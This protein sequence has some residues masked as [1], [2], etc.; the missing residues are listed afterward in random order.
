MASSSSSTQLILSLFLVVSLFQVSLASSRLFQV[1]L[2]TRRLSELVQDQS[3]LLKYHNGPLLN[4]KIAINLIWYG[5]FKPAQKAIVSDFITSLSSSSPAQSNKPSVAT[6]WKTTEKYYHLTSKKSSLSI[7]LGKQISNEKY[8][9]GKSLT[10][11][12][13]V[14]LASLGDQ[15]N[16]IN[17]VLTSADV[18]VDGFCMNRCGT[19]GAA[20]GSSHIR[21][22]NYKF[23]YIWV[24]NSE[25]QCPGLCAWPFHQPLYGPQSPPLVAPNNDV[26][27]DGM[28][29]NLASL[30]AGTA[31]NPFGNGYFQGPAEAPLEAASA[32]PG[33]YAKGAYPGYAGDLLVDA[34]TGA[35]YNANGANG[36]KYL[37]PALFDPSTSTCST[38]V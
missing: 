14:K 9:L 25:T 38:L 33:V 11:K 12:Q 1:S 32:C 8:S 18:A 27:L 3:Q 10:N 23:A 4:G 35:S 36:R 30:L 20:S 5:N 34:T 6:W 16:A 31:T 15:K 22:K 26:G 13:I 29:I 2:A 17:V 19:H 21:G 28:V 7:A 24:G 37:V